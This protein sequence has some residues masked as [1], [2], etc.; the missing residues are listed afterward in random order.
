DSTDA[1]PFPLCVSVKERPGLAIS[2]V[3][4]NNVLVDHGLTVRN[5]SLGTVVESHLRYVALAGGA[6]SCKRADGDPIPVRFRPALAN[7]PVTQGFDLANELVV[8]PTDDEHWRSASG[9]I[10]RD[11]H[12]ALPRI[13]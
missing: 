5:E 8:P 6:Q 12:E 11:P 10:A 7:A 3:L 2:V 9:L 4:G 13:L 1:L